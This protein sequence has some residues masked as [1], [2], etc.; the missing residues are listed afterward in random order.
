MGNLSVNQDCL[1]IAAL[2]LYSHCCTPPPYTN[3]APRSPH[4]ER[5]KNLLP[6]LDNTNVAKIVTLKYRCT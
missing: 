4:F 2:A 6:Q 1:R 5:F 3:M